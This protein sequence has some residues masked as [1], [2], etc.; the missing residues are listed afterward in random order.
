MLTRSLVG[1]DTLPYYVVQVS[2]AMI[3]LLAA[4]T[5]FSGFPRLASVLADDRFMPRQFAFRGE[6]LAFSF[7]IIALALVSIAVL[8]AFEGS[9]TKLVPALHDRGL[10]GV[11]ARR[12]AVWYGAGGACGIPAGG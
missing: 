8:S 4:N 9:V 3:L 10:P 11:H 5:G 1:D 6:R 7:G 2:T 12:R